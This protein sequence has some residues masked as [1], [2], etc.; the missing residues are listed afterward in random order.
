MRSEGTGNTADSGMVHRVENTWAIL[1]SRGVNLTAIFQHGK[2][3]CP[4][5]EKCVPVGTPRSMS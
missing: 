1:F 3:K 2:D 5:E 4:V